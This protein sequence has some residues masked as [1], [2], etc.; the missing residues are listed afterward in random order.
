VGEQQAAGE[1]KSF[2]GLSWKQILEGFVSFDEAGPHK[3]FEWHGVSAREDGLETTFGTLAF[4]DPWFLEKGARCAKAVCV[5]PGTA[6]GFL[7]APSVVLTNYH[8]FRSAAWARGMKILFENERD[9]NGLL[10]TAVSFD[11]DPDRLFKNSE[12]L[13]CAIVS[14]RSN[15]GEV[16]GF[17]DISREGEIKRGSR[18]NIVQHPNGS[19]KKIAVRDNEVQFVDDNIVQYLTD[20]E[21]GSSG[22]PVFNDN[23]EIIALHSMYD[24]PKNPAGNEFYN[25]GTRIARVW[26]FVKGTPIIGGWY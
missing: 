4:Q 24:K 16:Y 23:W 1:S 6:S 8:V 20:T 9:S 10:K 18:A 14:V 19:L 13:D 15:P 26:E 11:L 22:S 5:I 25:Q 12:A 17:I 2:D 21:H 7:I 3:T